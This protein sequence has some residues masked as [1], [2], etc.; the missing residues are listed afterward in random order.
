MMGLRNRKPEGSEVM[1]KL[2]LNLYK[3]E[4]NKT[5]VTMQKI[6]RSVYES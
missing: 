6:S 3:E 5:F 4:Q 2:L 1:K